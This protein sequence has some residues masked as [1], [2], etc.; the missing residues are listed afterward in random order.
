VRLGEGLL[1]VGPQPAAG[2]D[3]A[4]LFWQ[5]EKLHRLVLADYEARHSIFANEKQRLETESLLAFDAGGNASGWQTCWNEHLAALPGWRASLEREI[6]QNQK[7]KSK[8]T[9]N[10]SRFWSEQNAMDGLN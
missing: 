1:D 4:S 7:G 10:S 8:F 9:L 3:G 5:H 2:A 6:G